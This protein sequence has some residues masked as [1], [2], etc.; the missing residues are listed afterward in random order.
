MYLYNASSTMITTCI[1]GQNYCF[2]GLIH[3][4]LRSEIICNHMC[5]TVTVALLALSF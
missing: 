4:M 2:N 3:S 5:K 1:C